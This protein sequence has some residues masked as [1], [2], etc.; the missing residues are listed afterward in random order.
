MSL[1]FRV[2]TG[3]SI[4]NYRKHNSV[5]TAFDNSC[6]ITFKLNVFNLSKVPLITTKINYTKG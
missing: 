4:P 6:V 5:P 1:F 3:C 2:L